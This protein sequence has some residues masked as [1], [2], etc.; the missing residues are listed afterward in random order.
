M[1]TGPEDLLFVP[2]GGT[3]EIGMNLNL[4]G[5]DGQWIM[6]DLGVAFSDERL[7]GSDVFMADPAFIEANRD[8][9]AGI[10]LTHAHED[11]IGAVPHIWPRLRCPLYATAFTATMLRG[12]LA[13]AGLVNEASITEVPL[14]GRFSVGPFDLE[15]ITLTHSIPEPNAIAIRTKAG[16]VLHT[17]DW[18]LDPDPMIGETYDEAA[19]RRLSEEGVLAMVCDSTNALVEGESGS[20]AEVREQI[21]HL[22]ADYEHRIA[23][24]CFATNV[25]RLETMMHLAAAHGRKVALVGRSMHKV[26]QAALANGYLTDLPEVISDRE[27]GYLPRGEVLL[28]CTG[29]QGEPRAALW[30]IARGDH[31][32]IRLEPEDVAVFSSRVIPGN[33]K[34]ILSLQNSLVAQGIKV[35]T[36]DDHPIHVSGHPARDELSRMY[37]WVRPQV[38]IP[39]HGEVRH[40]VEHAELA[41]S[42]QV[43]QSIV[44]ANGDVIRLAPGTPGIVDQVPNGRLAL[45]GHRLV[46][47]ASPVFAE[48]RR[49]AQ[50]GSAA[51]TLVVD[52][53][54][55]LQYDPLL[56]LQ[57]VL[58]GE[59]EDE[60][61][62]QVLEYLDSE[63]AKFSVS[64]RRDDAL[65]H[66]AARVAVRRGVNQA[67]GKKPVTEVHLVRVS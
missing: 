31:P 11:H 15:L 4:Y 28:L 10:V 64:T 67:I 32:E 65:L 41:E 43:P 8:R 16:T 14:S 30:R 26:Y 17:G 61:M 60:I 58:D 44:A 49:L 56:S 52:A 25:A 21:N 20:E 48:R 22:L 40:L 45:D 27:V 59:D 38:S 24:A 18:K 63:I 62:D 7:P 37:Q 42:C 1:E 36:D 53:K 9:L 12:K 51:L 6:I 13:E 55:R 47:A 35:V 54:G 33:E 46:P 50:S 3:G 23:V 29:S 19:L 2:L 5:H 66:E 34:A 57:G 39:V